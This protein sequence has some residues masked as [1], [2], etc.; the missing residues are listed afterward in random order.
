[1]NNKDSLLL[2]VCV[3][4]LAGL[5][6][7]VEGGADRIELC[8]SLDLGGV[9]PSAGLMAEAARVGIPV[10]ALIRPRAGG[11]AYTAAEERVML[12]DIELVAELGLAGVA[13]GALGDDR[14]LD[15]AMIERLAARAAGLQLTLHRAFDLVPD[16][17]EALEQAITL[18]FQRILTSGGAVQAPAG[19]AQLAACVAQSRG[20]IRI[21]AGSGITPDNVG[22]LLAATGVQEVHAS[23]RA[24]GGEPPQ[25]LLA[26]GFASAS[27]G[28]RTSTAVVRDLKQRLLAHSK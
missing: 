7:A 12:S 26:F 14:R 27:S 5:H 25:D 16:P 17:A 22:A 1:M 24:P 13:I 2:E 20:R 21:L 3:D 28:R 9:T 8:S 18:G 6:A 15:L 19:T 4:D 10:V 11:F 23:C